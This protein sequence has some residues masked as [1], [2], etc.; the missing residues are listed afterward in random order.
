MSLSKE[1]EAKIVRYYHVEKW[2]I[3][4]IARQFGIHHSTVRR[5]LRDTGAAPRERLACKLMITPYLPFILETLDKYPRLTAS[6]LYGMVRERDYPG[7]EDHFRALIARFRPKKVAEAYLRLRTLPGEQAQVD[8]GHFGHLQIGEAKRP[9]MAFVMVLS[10][11][12]KIFLRFYLNAQMASFLRGHEAAFESFGG[13]PR[14][15]LYDNLKSAV[16]ER[17]GDAIRF[18]PTL[19]E[20]AGHYHFEPRPVA[21]ARGNEKGR[22]ERAIRY[23]RD[24]F[25]AGRTFKDLVDLN[26]QADQWSEGIAAERRCPEDTR[27]LIREAFLDE[28]DKLLALPDYPY[29]TDE[30]VEVQIGKTPYARFDLNDYSVPHTHVRRTLTVIGKPGKV[31]ILDGANILSEHVRSYDKGQQIEDPVHIAELIERKRQAAQQRGQDYLTKSSSKAKAL[32]VAAAAK[33]YCLRP[34]I[35]QL[36]KLL[37]LHGKTVLDAAIEEALNKGVPHPNAVRV[38][39][40]RQRE[41]TANSS[42]AELHLSDPR[43]K[44]L[45]IKP[46]PLSNYAPQQKPEENDE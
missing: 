38:A 17:E 33:G 7:G 1:K 42:P 36:E 19:L 13:V 39:L 40:E 10:Y 15:L 35:A 43:L 24:N 5:V 27:L 45:L 28:Q 12:R 20:F 21:V 29:A 9:L 22:V 44:E 4:T 2:K 16:L 46:H 11:S 8:W 32:L 18:N 3:G 41:L 23:I 34:I 30:R 31:L 26:Q 37:S 6:R 14:V 25:F